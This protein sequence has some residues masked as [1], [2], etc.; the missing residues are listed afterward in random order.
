MVPF[1]KPSNVTRHKVFYLEVARRAICSTL[2]VNIIIIITSN[3]VY[4]ECST[5]K[6]CHA[7]EEKNRMK[8]AQQQQQNDSPFSVHISKNMS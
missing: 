4:I 7:T 8:Y 3:D 2:N 6:K 5:P 1:L